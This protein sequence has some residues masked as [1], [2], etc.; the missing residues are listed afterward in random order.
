MAIAEKIKILCENMPQ[1]KHFAETELT[2]EQ[3]KEIEEIYNFYNTEVFLQQ[4]LL[5]RKKEQR[6]FF[7]KKRDALPEELLEKYAILAAEKISNLPEYKKSSLVFIPVSFGSELPTSALISQALKDSKRVAVP[8]VRGKNMMLQEITE[9][10]T[11]HKA[12]FGILEPDDEKFVDENPDFT[13]LPALA[14]SRLGFR[15]GYG[16]GYYDRFL[17]GYTGISVGVCMPG[18]TVS[19]IPEKWDYPADIMIFL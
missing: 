12:A 16:G 2:A 15:V 1:F 4:N 7:R 5:L 9:Q 14:F 13:F 3:N 11:Y 10:T 6:A 17:S 19:V 18:F 8:A